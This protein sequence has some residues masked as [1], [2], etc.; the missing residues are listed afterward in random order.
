MD[1]LARDTGGLSFFYSDSLDVISN[2][3]NEAFTAI[4]DTDVGTN[5]FD[6]RRTSSAFLKYASIGSHFMIEIMWNNDDKSKNT[7]QKITVQ[8]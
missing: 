1:S 7:L 8:Q 4:E 3:L 5:S 6:S 2:A